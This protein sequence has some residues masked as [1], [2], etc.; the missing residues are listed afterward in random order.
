MEL[1][2]GEKLIFF[3]DIFDFSPIVSWIL[4]RKKDSNE[5]GLGSDNQIFAI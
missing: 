1:M 4:G 3:P 2:H 5:L